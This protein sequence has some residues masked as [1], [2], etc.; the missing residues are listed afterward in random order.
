MNQIREMVVANQNETIRKQAS[1]EN[2]FLAT[3][4]LMGCVGVIFYNP[5]NGLVKWFN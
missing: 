4:G 3:V 2:V 1:Q 5:Q